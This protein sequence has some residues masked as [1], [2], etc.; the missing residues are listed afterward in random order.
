M[1]ILAITFPQIDPVFFSIGPS[2][3]AGTASPTRVRPAARL[4]LRALAG[5]H[6][7]PWGAVPHPSKQSLDDLLVYWRS[8]P[9]SAA[10]C[11][12]C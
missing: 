7:P 4:A 3:S 12:R 2:P 5:I 1:P 8:A 6:R 11:S 9:C 10:G